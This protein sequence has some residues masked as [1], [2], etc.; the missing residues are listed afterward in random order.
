MKVALTGATGHLGA[1]L[2]QEL[3]SRNIGIKALIRGNDTRTSDGMPV[4]IIKGE[5][6]DAHA[7]AKLMQGCDAVIH[8]A[9]V[10]SVNGDAVGLLQQTNVVG[11]QMVV[12]VALQAG[13]KRFIHIRT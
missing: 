11:T 1:A 5:I 13:I 9:A 10:I 6:M 8:C 2:I 7:L 12:D 3:A 4:E